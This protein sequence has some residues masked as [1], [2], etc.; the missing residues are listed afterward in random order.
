MLDI[1]KLD[2]QSKNITKEQK[3]E[4]RKLFPEVFTED[5]IDFKKLRLTLGDEIDDGEERFGMTWPGKRDCFKVIQEPSIATLKP[6]KE[7]SVNWDTTE[8]LF[9]EGDNLEVLKQLQKSYY[10]KIKMI[11]I[12]PP[13]NTGKEFIYPDK[14]SESLETYLA[15]TGQ[16]D[17]EGRKFSTNTESDGRFHSKWLNMMYPRLFL[18][19]NLLGE[20]GIIFVSIDDNE[21]SS[22]RQLMN[23][24]F[25]ENNFVGS[26]AW[27]NKYGAGA[28]TKGFIEVHEYILCY[29]KG[30]FNYIESILSEEQIK[31][32]EKIKDDKYPIR[33]GFVTQPLMTNSLDDR[34]NLQYDIEYNGEIIKPRKQWVWE[35]NRLLKAIENDEIVIKKK[36]DG[37]YSVRAKAYLKDENGIIRKGKPLSLLNG[38]FNQE[39]TKEV[40]DLIGNGIFSFP[41]PSELV[42][43]F[44]GFTINNVED[45]DG[46]YLDFF[47]GSCATAH[48]VLELNKVDGGNRKFIM[49]QLPEPCDEKTEAYKAGYNTIAAIGKERI[50]R[51]IKKIK[52]EFN[53]EDPI[54]LPEPDI[55]LGFKVFKLDKSNFKIWDGDVEEKPIQEQLELAIDHIDPNSSEEDI[56]CE[57]LLKSGFELTTPIEEFTLEGKKVYSIAEGALLICL[58]KKL[59]NEVMRAIAEREPHRVVCLDTGF[60]GN[61]RLK[62]NAVQIMKSFN[63]ESFRTV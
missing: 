49:V 23:E 55:D 6:C 52:E 9:I 21:V 13:Y 41:K 34:E 56:L 43:Y 11:Y 33:G 63:V 36:R 29:S 25:G 44:V 27:K 17:D 4:F 40:A 37:E 48:A 8:N 19:R 16:I 38:P 28:K 1:E 60:K 7:E 31:D 32:Y 14:Y 59:T 18:A 46:I 58:E 22:L 51:V 53:S 54:S 61:D 10:G 12:D 47:A 2:L 35:K 39:G 20:D 3:A 15:Y 50:R 57:I 42:K 5:K 45:K 24:I 26:I 62:T 30:D